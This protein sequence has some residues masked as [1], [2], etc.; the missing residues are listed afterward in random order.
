[1][2]DTTWVHNIDP[3]L[4]HISGNFGIRWYG[5]AYVTGFIGGFLIMQW[6]AKKKLSPMTVE[7]ASDFITYLIFGV[8][9]G[10]RMGYALFYKPE[11]LTDFT[12]DFPFW[13]VLAVWEGGMA[14]HGGFAGV[15]IACFLFA[16]KYKMPF[17]HV[18]DM[19]ILGATVG[20]FAGRM[21]NFINGELM[22]KI[23]EPGFA[24]GVKFPQDIYRWITNHPEKLLKLDRVAEAAGVSATTWQSWMNNIRG[25]NHNIWMFVNDMIRQ[26]QSGDNPGLIEEL[27]KVLPARH[28]SQLYAACT[29]ALI[30]AI[31]ILFVWKKARKPGLICSLYYMIYAV[32][33]IFNEN[34][35]L[36]D[37][38]LADLSQLPLGISRGQF[39][40]IFIFA[41]GL[42]FLIYTQKQDV[43]RLG[44]WGKVFE[45]DPEKA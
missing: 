40:S 10:G 20:I 11:L 41:I 45:K 4:I 19:T 15:L 26:V 35:R 25:A 18:G 13:G 28:P 37:S 7:Q 34:F 36:P 23:C 12:A 6:F 16:R 3:F 17:A 1:M 24:L 44:G 39:L 32:G 29:E 31:V 9:G 27:A 30:P 22:G 21:A 14:S 33:R 38:H 2:A 42:G 5:L 8:L 43:P